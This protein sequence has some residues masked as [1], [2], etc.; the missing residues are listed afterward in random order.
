[1]QRRQAKPNTTQKYNY[2]W[3]LDGRALAAERVRLDLKT[4][5]DQSFGRKTA[6]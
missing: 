5:A 2:T 3:Q 4:S 1:L 6:R